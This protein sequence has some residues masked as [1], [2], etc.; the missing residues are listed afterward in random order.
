MHRYLLFLLALTLAACGGGDN[1][2]DAIP[3]EEKFIPDYSTPVGATTAFIRAIESE[4]T[5]L[6]SLT[7]LD[8]EREKLLPVYEDKFRQSKKLGV[9][10]KL[11]QVEEEWVPNQEARSLFQFIEM[12]DGKETGTVTGGWHVFVKTADGT[13]KY[14]NAASKRWVAYLI[15]Q[16]KQ[17]PAN[18]AGD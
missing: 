14:S 6:L 15:E 1:S 8:D 4:N 16:E 18:S 5:G 12:K 13:W 2:A 10:W 9:K 17:A 7:L 3:A 11:K